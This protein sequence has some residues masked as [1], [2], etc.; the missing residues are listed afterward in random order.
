MKIKQL[1]TLAVVALTLFS[2]QALES[3]DDLKARIQPVGSVHIAGAAAAGAAA[4]ASGPRSGED[5]Y[6][7]ACAACH[8]AGV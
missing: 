1:V 5:I 3:N 8:S 7:G 6:K 2:V 4:A